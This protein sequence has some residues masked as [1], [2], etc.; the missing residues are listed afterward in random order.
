[1]RVRYTPIEYSH[2]FNQVSTSYEVKVVFK[3]SWGT[4]S[5]ATL[6]HIPTP[7]QMD[8]WK[9]YL[10][11]AD[12]KPVSRPKRIRLVPQAKEERTVPL[13]KEAEFLE[14]LKSASP[15][16]S[17]SEGP[18]ASQSSSIPTRS[19]SSKKKKL[20]PQGRE[21]RGDLMRS[22]DFMDML[23][24]GRDTP[25]VPPKPAA[26]NKNKKKLIPAGNEEKGGMSSSDLMDML[27]EGPDEAMPSTKPPPA[28][29]SVTKAKS[30]KKSAAP[31]I[32]VPPPAT[33][34]TDG[35]GEKEPVIVKKRVK[36]RDPYDIDAMMK[37]IEDDSDFNEDDDPKVGSRK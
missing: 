33:K 21:E 32:K 8:E 4:P 2:K 22:S 10:L 24:E 25:P 31:A 13:L 14:A 6:L 28:S 37:E 26:A 23:N 34:N 30:V 11:T 29:A 16:E 15:S 36:A 17:L 3:K 18:Q 5:V 27:N 7:S 9:L 1:M 12:E 20:I 35:E 19:K